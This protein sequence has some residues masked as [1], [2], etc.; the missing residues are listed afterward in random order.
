MYTYFRRCVN[1]MSYAIEFKKVNKACVPKSYTF[2][3]NKHINEGVEWRCTHRDCLS[4]LHHNESSTVIFRC[5][6]I[7]IYITL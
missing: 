4:K 5:E 3:K 7:N 2:Y 6:L 1:K